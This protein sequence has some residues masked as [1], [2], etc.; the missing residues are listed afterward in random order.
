MLH[1]SQS[2]ARS[3]VI[4]V[5]KLSDFDRLLRAVCVEYGFCGS[6]QDIGPLHVVDFIPERG[7]FSVDQFIEWLYMAEGE[8]QSCSTSQVV[9]RE[10]LR[11]CFIGYM[12]SGVVTAYN[13]R[14]SCSTKA[15]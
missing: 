11:S 9:L 4:S 5:K 6:L 13:L 12:G 15:K 8:K 3:P 7:K 14:R 10:K 2:C 1:L